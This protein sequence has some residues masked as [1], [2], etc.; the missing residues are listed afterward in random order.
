VLTWG[1]AG[2]R[3]GRRVPIVF[4][5][6]RNIEEAKRLLK[7]AGYSGTPITLGSTRGQDTPG[8]RRSFARPP[9]RASNYRSRIWPSRAY[10]EDARRR[11]TSPIYGGGGVGEPLVTND[12]YTRL[13]ATA[14]RREQRR[15]VLH[16]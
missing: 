9:K 14:S 15:Q 3:L 6:K 2:T 10:P 7:E 12:Q 16:S 8:P 4:K 11:F 1:V 13:R 5:W